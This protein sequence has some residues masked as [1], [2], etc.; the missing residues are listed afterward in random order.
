M[1]K[2]LVALAAAF[3]LLLAGGTASAGGTANPANIP[4]H[5]GKP[6]QRFFFKQPLPAFQA[7]P[8]YL[9]YPYNAHFMTPAPTPD[10]DFG[11]AGPGAYPPGGYTNPYFPGQYGPRR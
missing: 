7:A 3:G 2:L 1:K 11:P 10:A 8:W 9:Y 6:L 5:N 4:T